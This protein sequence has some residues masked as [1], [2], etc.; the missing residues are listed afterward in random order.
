[1]ALAIF[2]SEITENRYPR[3]YFRESSNLIISTK[4]DAN[5]TGIGLYLAKNH[6]YQKYERRN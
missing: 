4:E 6:Y 5:G 1:M 2:F 3:M